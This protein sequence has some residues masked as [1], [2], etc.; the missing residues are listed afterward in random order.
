[1]TLP[2]STSTRSNA[3]AR[4]GLTSRVAR[5]MP[6]PV[7]TNASTLAG[8]P[9]SLW[10]NRTIVSPFVSKCWPGAGHLPHFDRQ[11]KD[12][13]ASCDPLTRLHRA[14]GE[15]REEGPSNC[16]EAEFHDRLRGFRRSAPG[17][18]TLDQSR[19]ARRAS[20]IRD[21]PELRA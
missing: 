10:N 3:S 16:R 4:A 21:L 17:K 9:G 13:D 7:V 18:T 20:A 5:P 14:A 6:A 15:G 11:R 12:A 8:T 2:V 1:M 19:P